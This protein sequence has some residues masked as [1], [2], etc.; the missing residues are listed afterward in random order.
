[1]GLKPILPVK[2]PVT[3]GTMLSLDG[4]GEDDGHGMGAC[5]HTLTTSKKDQKELVV[6]DSLL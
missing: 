3:N 6:F 2:V 5:K 1:M 4:N